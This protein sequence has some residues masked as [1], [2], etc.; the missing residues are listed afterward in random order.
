MSIESFVGRD[1]S[2]RIVIDGHET[3]FRAPSLA[4]ARDKVRDMAIAHAVE[5]GQAQHFIARSV[6][7]GVYM[8]LLM[9]AWGR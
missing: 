7:G 4:E 1:G 2:A 6:Q 8:P 5:T 3:K 9:K